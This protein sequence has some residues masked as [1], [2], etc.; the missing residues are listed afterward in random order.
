MLAGKP[1]VGSRS[2]GTPEIISP[3]ETGFLYSPGH[4]GQLAEHIEY[5]MEHPEALSRMGENGSRIARQR[6]SLERYGERI[7]QLIASVM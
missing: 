2:G 3:G 1:V 6:F 5:F 7:V 4:H